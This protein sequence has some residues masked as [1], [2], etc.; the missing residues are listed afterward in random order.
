MSGL[1]AFVVAIVVVGVVPAVLYL[2][3]MRFGRFLGLEKR[4]RDKPN[5]LGNGR[6]EVLE[7]SVV[8]GDRRLVLV[9][10]DK[11][12]HL[13]L[14]GGPADVVVENDV[15]KVRGPGAP[16]PK[17]LVSGSADTAGTDKAADDAMAL[18][19]AGIAARAR[20]T[21]AERR[22]P[23]ISSGTDEPAA[24][25]TKP[26]SRM[27]RRTDDTPRGQRERGAQRPAIQPTPLGAGR[28]E[29]QPSPERGNGGPAES[30]PELPSAGVPWA[31][32]DSI[33]PDSI[34]NE[35]VRALRVDPVA[36]GGANA[37]SP[38]Q[39]AA[40][41]RDASDSSTT[42]GDL[43]DRLEE[44]LAQEVQAASQDSRSVSVEDFAFDSGPAAGAET[45]RPSA[46]SESK[47]RSLKRDS[48]KPEGIAPA[49][50]PDRRQQGTGE[51]RE[52]APVISLSS[53]RRETADPLEDEMAR[54][55]GELTGD[56]KGR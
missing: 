43:A 10:C 25:N 18:T 24:S 52:E 22:P 16:A 55:L 44:A 20:L 27:R 13:I 56:N 33:A 11:I 36:R 48:T 54:L 37:Q 12:E 7:S 28:G 23:A 2:L 21:A 35:I 31:E 19:D 34:E 29:R 53:R 14:V 8:D 26:P 9:R 3:Y 46:P 32:P 6:I 15:R 4:A 30:T 42:L 49:P 50:E 17:G 5:I 39:P 41:R 45:S 47:A 38:Q 1:G 40:S 51:R